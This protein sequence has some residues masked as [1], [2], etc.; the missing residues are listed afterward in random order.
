MLGVIIGLCLEET[1]PEL[2]KIVGIANAVRDIQM[3]AL[4][5]DGEIQ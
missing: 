1:F 4:D 3:H 5:V 2:E